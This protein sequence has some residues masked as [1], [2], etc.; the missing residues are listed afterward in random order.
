M[1]KMV[2]AFAAGV[3]AYVADLQSQKFTLPPALVFLYDPQTIKPWTEIDSLLV[4]QRLAFELSYDANSDI[5]R[6]Q[7]QAA[8]KLQFDDSTTAGA[9]RAQ[10]HRRRLQHPGAARSDLHATLG[11][12]RDERRQLPR[13]AETPTSTRRCCRSWPRRAA[14]SPAWATTIRSLR[15]SVATTGSSDRSSRRRG[16]VMVANDTHL[17]LRNPPIFYLV[18]LVVRGRLDAMGV[19]FPGLPGIILGMNE[20]VAWGATV[21]NI[22]VTDVYRET[23]ATCDDGKSPCVLFNGAKVALVPRTETI[24]IGRFGQIVKYRRRHPVRR[25]A[26]RADHPARHDRPQRRGAGDE[27]AVDPLHRARAGAASWPRCSTASTRAKSMKDAV[28]AIDAGFIYGNQNWVIGD[29]QGHFGWTAVHAHAAARG[30]GRAVEDPARRR[31]RR[32]GRR[33]GSD[34]HPARVR[35]GAGL[36]RDREQRS[37]RRHRRRRSVLRRADGRRRPAL[38]RR[39]LRSGDARR[40]HHQAHQGASPTPAAS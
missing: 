8:A 17:S 1:A 26:P 4:G 13:L 18:H 37:D 9:Q 31:Q 11:L 12:D 21:N 2:T 33:Y 35:S 14:P 32:M 29:D 3:N 23:V 39:R 34:L 28:A 20:H 30:H 22:D 15:A 5:Y 19:Q 27:R 10:G 36:H 38:P 24:H 25:A 40:A 7:L 16:H 6:S